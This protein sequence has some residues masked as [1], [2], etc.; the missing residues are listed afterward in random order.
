MAP[1]NLSLTVATYPMSSN[2]SGLYLFSTSF[3]VSTT[4]KSKQTRKYVRTRTRDALSSALY[5]R[6]TTQVVERGSLRGKPSEPDP[7]SLLNPKLLERG[8]AP[9]RPPCTLQAGGGCVNRA[10]VCPKNAR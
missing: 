9:D 7:G 2:P 1:L 4:A 3:L 8:E 6:A 5:T 10:P